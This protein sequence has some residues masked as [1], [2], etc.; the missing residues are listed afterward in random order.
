MAV[1]AD[2]HAAVK[3]QPWGQFRHKKY[4]VHRHGA[5]A[6]VVRLGTTATKRGCTQPAG[7]V[8]SLSRKRKIAL[9]TVKCVPYL[10]LL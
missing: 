4:L 9:S 6:E 8:N 2:S 5:K 1:I 10:L 7:C 3:G